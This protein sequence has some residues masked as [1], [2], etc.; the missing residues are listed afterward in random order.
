MTQ[1]QSIKRNTNNN[2]SHFLFLSI[3][4]LTFTSKIQT[5]SNTYTNP[6]ISNNC[7]D[8][9]VISYLNE[10]NSI[11]YV[12]VVT[13]NDNTDAFPMYTSSDLINWTFLNYVF[14]RGS[15]NF[16]Q[17]AVSDFWAPE[18]HRINETQWNLYFAA[19]NGEGNLCVGVAY[20]NSPLGPFLPTSLPLVCFLFL[21][22][23]L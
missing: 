19:R 12:A 9:G 7:P 5:K 11:E 18:I 22:I 10:K 15:P 6:A 17:W 16:P 21:L 4:L 2:L 14:P 3:I 13:S 23:I 8:P 20:S 1:K